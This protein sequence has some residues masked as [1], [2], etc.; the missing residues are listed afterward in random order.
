VKRTLQ[1]EIDCGV[2]TCASAPGKFCHFAST[3]SFGTK[4]V[5]SLWRDADGR[6]Q[7]LYDIGGWLTRCRQCCEAELDK[8]QEGNSHGT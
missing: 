7:S 5:C 1:I 3:A 8:R 6:P 4:F 2:E